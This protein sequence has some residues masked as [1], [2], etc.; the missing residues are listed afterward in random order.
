[1]ESDDWGVLSVAVPAGIVVGVPLSAIFAALHYIFGWPHNLME[2]C[3]L[4]FAVPFAIVLI[5]GTGE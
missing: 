1:M 5:L 2:A 3:G 4:S